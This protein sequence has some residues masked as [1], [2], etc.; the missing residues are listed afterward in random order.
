MGLLYLQ[1]SGM[2]ACVRGRACPSL[3]RWRGLLLVSWLCEGLRLN[4]LNYSIRTGRQ[5]RACHKTP[6]L[7]NSRITSLFEDKQPYRD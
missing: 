4:G 1:T 6:A 5:K 2:S 3:V 7:V